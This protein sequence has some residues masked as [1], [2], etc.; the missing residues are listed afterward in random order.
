MTEN[1]QI[2][3]MLKKLANP[4]LS[5]AEKLSI[6]KEINEAVSQFNKLVRMLNALIKTE[7]EK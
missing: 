7:N 5:S 3:D 4:E 1:L 6:L 2:S